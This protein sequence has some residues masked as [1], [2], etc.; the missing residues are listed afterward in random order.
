MTMELAEACPPRYEKKR[1]PH[2]RA[3][4]CPSPSSAH[5]NDRGGNPLGCAYGNLRAPRAT[6]KNVPLPVGRGACPS[7]CL[8]WGN[9]FGWRAVFAQVG[10]SRGKPAR[11]RGWHPRAPALRARKG[12]CHVPFGI[13]RSRTTVTRSSFVNPAPGN[14]KFSS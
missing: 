5:S 12:F 9:G 8:G 10:R 13:R 6:K 3:R 1:P 11:M 14:K 7:P 4:A 2:R